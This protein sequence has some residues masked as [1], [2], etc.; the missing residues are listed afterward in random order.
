LQFV[1]ST[2][3]GFEHWP[4]AGLQVPATWHWSEAVQATV[5]PAV[6]TPVLHVSF[7]SHWFPSLQAVPSATIGFEHCPVVGLHVPAAWHWSDAVHVT[8][9][10]AVQAPAWQVS[11]RSQALPS[12]HAVPFVTLEYWVVLTP[13]WHV[14]HVLVPLVA[15]AATHAPPIEQKPALSVGAE[16]TPVELLQ[17]PAV[18]HESGAAHVTWLPAVHVPDWHVSLRSQ[19]F[20]SLQ[21]VPLLTFVYADVLALGWHDSQVLV[22]LVAPAGTHAPPIEQKPALSVGAEQSPVEVL[23]VPAVWHES[24]AAHVMWLPA[25]HVPDWHVSLRSQAFPSL[26]DVPLLTFV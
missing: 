8:W 7:R 19:A 9:L 18:W 25:V 14:S 24:G 10:P 20:P 3:V 11:L 13:G 2:A 4:V 1:P 6:H 22:P 26:Q 21:D 17:V 23:H 5:L 15:P 12:L 16:Q